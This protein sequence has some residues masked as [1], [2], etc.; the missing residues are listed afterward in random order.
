MSFLSTLRATTN[1]N[2]HYFYGS[3][4]VILS[5]HGLLVPAYFCATFGHAAK[6]YEKR[7]QDDSIWSR[8]ATLYR[9]IIMSIRRISNK[10]GASQLS[11]K[12]TLGKV[13]LWR[14]HSNSFLRIMKMNISQSTNCLP[15]RTKHLWLIQ[16]F[17]SEFLPLLWFKGDY[18]ERYKQQQYTEI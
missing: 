6:F 7:A 10:S 5:N 16:F 3:V 18:K 17:C 12:L 15:L 14:L 4:L 9:T 8:F 13:H 2:A 1:C 11:G